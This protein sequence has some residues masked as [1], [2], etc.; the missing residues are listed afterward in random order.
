MGSEVD[1]ERLE[2]AVLGFRVRQ[3]NARTTS[4][5]PPTTVLI[6]SPQATSR[7]TPTLP[8]NR[9]TRFIA[10]FAVVFPAI[11]KL[12]P[13][14]AMPKTGFGMSAHARTAIAVR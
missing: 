14:A 10:C 11:A 5:A 12:R 7:S 9:L 3:S 2:L 13:M 6:R 8:K 4:W 1:T